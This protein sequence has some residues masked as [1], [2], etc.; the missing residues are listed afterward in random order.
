M[1]SPNTFHYLFFRSIPSPV[2]INHK[3][4]RGAYLKRRMQRETSPILLFSHKI[5]FALFRCHMSYVHVKK[6]EKKAYIDV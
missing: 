5:A 1:H 2:G 6:I 4:F 3:L